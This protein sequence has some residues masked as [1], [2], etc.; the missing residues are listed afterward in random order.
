MV[1]PSCLPTAALPTTSQVESTTQGEQII[2]I[3]SCLAV[4]ASLPSVSVYIMAARFTVI[5]I[6]IVAWLCCTPYT[7]E[8]LIYRFY[9][10]I[11]L[12]HCHVVTTTLQMLHSPYWHAK[13]LPKITLWKYNVCTKVN[14]L[15][16]YCP[17]KCWMVLL[18]PF[19]IIWKWFSDG[20]TVDHGYWE[21]I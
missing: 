1:N 11:S 18:I 10:H 12:Y 17:F 3:I 9:C 21:Q 2:T 19:V 8:E 15:L 20:S 6:H 14:L 7:Q 5:I 16:T 4:W 13:D